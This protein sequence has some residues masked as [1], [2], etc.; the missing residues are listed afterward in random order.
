VDHAMLTDEELQSFIENLP[1]EAELLKELEALGVARERRCRACNSSL[2]LYRR[3]AVW[4]SSA[5][6]RWGYEQR[7]KARRRAASTS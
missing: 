6:K 5:C 7:V 2:A 3:D 4:C 1:S